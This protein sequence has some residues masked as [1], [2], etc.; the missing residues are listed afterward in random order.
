MSENRSMTPAGVSFNGKHSLD[1]Y[2]LRLQPYTI[3]LPTPKFALIDLPGGNGT[4]D[5]TEESG[6][7][8]YDDRVFT[9]TL[10]SI[11]KTRQ[12]EGL[13]AR[14][15]NDIHGKR[16]PV[17]FDR[18]PTYYYDA[19]C[20]VVSLVPKGPLA[21]ITVELT[22]KPFRISTTLTTKTVTTSD[23]LTSVSLDNDRAPVTPT[24]TVSSPCAIRMTNG[25]ILEI[26]AAG[27][28]ELYDL[29]LRPGTNT[30]SILYDTSAQST[31]EPLTVTFSYRKGRL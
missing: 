26:D 7:V 16:I 8:L 13:A 14:L 1:Y 9:L 23:I 24:V 10:Q 12:F 30:V 4:A 15:A 3:P 11:L 2:G 19:R 18:D 22:A 20:R 27:T 21:S 5:L 29:V 28:Y 6:D 25:T 17:I 31:V